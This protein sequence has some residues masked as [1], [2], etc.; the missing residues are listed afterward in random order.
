M[1]PSFIGWYRILIHDSIYIY[2]YILLYSYIEYNRCTYSQYGWLYIASHFCWLML[3]LLLWFSITMSTARLIS[4]PPFPQLVSGPKC[5]PWI[6]HNLLGKAMRS[7]I[8]PL[9]SM[10]YR[11][12]GRVVVLSQKWRM[13]LQKEEDPGMTGKN[14]WLPVD[15]PGNSSKPL[16]GGAGSRVY[17]YDV[18]IISTYIPII[19]LSQLLGFIVVISIHNAITAMIPGATGSDGAPPSY[20]V[21]SKWSSH[22]VIIINYYIL[23]LPYD[24]GFNQ[25]FFL[26]WNSH[27]LSTKHNISSDF[28]TPF[29]VLL[30]QSPVLEVPE[31]QHQL[32]VLWF[33][34]PPHWM[35]KT[36]QFWKHQFSTI[37]GALFT[38]NPRPPRLRP[39]RFG[40]LRLLELSPVSSDARWIHGLNQGLNPWVKI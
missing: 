34:N 4:Y 10:D 37:S 16:I 30:N 22:Y 13:G 21:I 26:R 19:Q 20:I 5:P 14:P 39:G 3:I 28:S 7:V 35:W 8:L 31:V 2:I 29:L 36:T 33:K 32:N 23:M 11:G 17:G 15:V 18:W 40:A 1:P 38:S 6:H 24:C 27:V 9:T 25:V 12:Y